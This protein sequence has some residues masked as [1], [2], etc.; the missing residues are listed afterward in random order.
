MPVYVDKA[1]NSF[2]RMVMCHMIADS[3]PELHEIAK[4]IG[5][6]REWFQP[7]SFPHYDVSLSRRKTA[8]SL[9]AI[10]I[11]RQEIAAHMK[12]IRSKWTEENILEIRKEI[13]ERNL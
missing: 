7:L 3:F 11:S 1:R 8:V 12:R 2:G 10:E 9:G 13:Q 6:K 5:M 4:A